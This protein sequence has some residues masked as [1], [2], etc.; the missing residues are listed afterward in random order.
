VGDRGRLLFSTFQNSRFSG[1]YHDVL[2]YQQAK[3]IGLSFSDGAMAI[4]IL[5]V[6]AFLLRKVMDAHGKAAPIDANTDLP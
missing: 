2:R 6:F 1:D 3:D 5:R 4:G